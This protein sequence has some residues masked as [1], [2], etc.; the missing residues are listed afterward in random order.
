MIELARFVLFLRAAAALDFFMVSRPILLSLLYWRA[1]FFLYIFS[2]FWAMHFVIDCLLARMQ[3]SSIFA[4]NPRFLS[5]TTAALLSS[6]CG[7]GYLA[8]FSRR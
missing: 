4:T 3:T 8:P 7:T 2:T 5:L 1:G 6:E